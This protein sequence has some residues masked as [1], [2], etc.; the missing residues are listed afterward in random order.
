VTSTT[1]S[2]AIFLSQ[3]KKNDSKGISYYIYKNIK[4]VLQWLQA[5]QPDKGIII[6][7]GAAFVEM[8][9][10]IRSRGI[11]NCWMMMVK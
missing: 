8:S 5:V 10:S 7:I 11:S 4:S 6:H 3:R 2:W 1:L 9:F